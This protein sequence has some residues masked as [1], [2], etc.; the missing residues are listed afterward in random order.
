MFDI[1]FEKLSAYFSDINL[2]TILLFALFLLIITIRFVFKN[3]KDLF[4]LWDYFYNKQKAHEE[5]MAQ[6]KKAR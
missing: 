4:G 1:I 2:T 3:K 5:S 6:I